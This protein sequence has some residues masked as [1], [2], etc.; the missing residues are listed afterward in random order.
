MRYLSLYTFAL[1]ALLVLRAESCKDKHGTTQTTLSKADSIQ[2]ADSLNRIRMAIV[3][4]SIRN[5]QTMIDSEPPN[6][7]HP[8]ALPLEP[9]FKDGRAALAQFIATNTKYPQAAKEKNITGNVIVMFMVHK[10]GTL[11]DFKIQQGL[12]Y[13]CDEEAL[14]VAKLMPPWNPG[15]KDGKVVDMEYMIIVPFKAGK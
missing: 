4:D 5:A 8:P 14:R 11:S 10:D 6:R 12:G 1:F 9:T 13:G 7:H 2:I 3:Q 15:K